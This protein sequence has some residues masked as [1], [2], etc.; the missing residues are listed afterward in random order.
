[1]AATVKV[2]VFHGAGTTTDVSGIEVRYKQADNDTPDLSNP[3]PIPSSGVGYSYPKFMKLQWL[4]TPAQKIRNLRWYVDPVPVTGDPA[5]DWVGL[6]LWAGLTASYSV[7]VAGDTN[8]LRAGLTASADFWTVNNPLVIEPG[9]LLTN[10]SVG[11]GATQKFLQT[12]LAVIPSCLNGVK[13]ARQTW[14]RWEEV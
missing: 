4:T 13:A 6:T 7:G 14:Y 8:A 3:I 1:M 2:Y 11:Y 12:Q 9:D 5:T 10:P